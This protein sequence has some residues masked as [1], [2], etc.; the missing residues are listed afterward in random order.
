MRPANDFA[1]KPWG[2][3][4][5]FW[6]WQYLNLWKTIKLVTSKR[7]K[8]FYGKFPDLLPPGSTFPHFALKDI[9]GNLHC[10]GDYL[11][12]KYMVVTTGAIT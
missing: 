6:S 9:H 1:S 5:G 4:A 11:G 7:V 12:K 2:P 10:M 3:M 8:S